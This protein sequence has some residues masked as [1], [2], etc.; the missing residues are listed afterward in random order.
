MLRIFRWRVALVG[1]KAALI[2]G[3]A[4]ICWIASSRLRTGIILGLRS[5]LFLAH[6]GPFPSD[7]GQKASVPEDFRE[8]NARA[9]DRQAILYSHSGCVR[10]WREA[11]IGSCSPFP[12]AVQTE[13]DKSSLQ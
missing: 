4:A 7:P 2:D 12:S 10:F 1:R 9:K 5:R 11:A 6:S 8:K 13:S 3:P